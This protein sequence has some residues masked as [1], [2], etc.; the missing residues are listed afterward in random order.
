MKIIDA[1]AHIFNTP[2]Y[3]K[4]L[5][6][7]MDENG[8]EKACISGIGDIFGSVTNK[9][10][11]ELIKE[12]PDRF[13]G[14]YYIRPGKS[15]ADEIAAAYSQ[16][17]QMIKVTMTL[18]PYDDSSLYPLWKKAEDYKMPILFHTGILTTLR[19]AP[20]ERISSWNMHPMR[21]EPIANAFPKLNLII[22]HL[23]VH[24]NT[25]AAELARMRL[26]VFVDLTGEPT[27]WRLHADAM[28]MTH[29]LWWPK[30]FEKVIFGT[31][32]IP[33]KIATILNQDKERYR[34]LNLP[35]KTQENI[36][37]KTILRLIGEKTR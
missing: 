18:K 5:L 32:V 37:G 10:I 13:I 22:A 26:N 9:D 11:G 20:E 28:G 24:W 8:I 12:Y 30:A 19:S 17:F 4:N 14:A 33:P 3:V 35:E 15:R 31:D 23:G 27:G 2:N 6:Q 1:H 36:F 29:F 16:G 34:K 25:D 7:A 21:L